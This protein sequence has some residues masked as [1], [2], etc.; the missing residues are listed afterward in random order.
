MASLNLSAA[1]STTVTWQ[2]VGLGSPFNT[3]NYQKVVL[4]S[5]QLAVD[6]STTPPSNI[7]STINAPSSGSSTSTSS[8]TTSGGS[9]FSAGN[10]Y[11]LYATAQ[12][13]SGDNRYYRAGSA[14]VTMPLERPS[15]FSWTYTKSSNQPFNLTAAE[16]NSFASKVNSFRAYKGLGSYGFTGVSPDMPFYWW[17]YNQGVNSISPMSPSYPLP[18]TQSASG[19]IIYASYLNDL[20]DS[21]NSIS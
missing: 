8:Q 21:L 2:V 11:T 12:L 18:P 17:I 20:R 6:G 16:W 7:L 13:E 3:S 4:S 5:N 19:G 9:A 15:N 10:T 1:S 14:S